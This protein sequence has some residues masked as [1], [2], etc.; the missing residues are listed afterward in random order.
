MSRKRNARWQDM[1]KGNIELAQLIKHFESFNRSERKS[2]RTVEWY[3]YVLEFFHKWLL[4]SGRATS[5]GGLDE[6]VARDFILYLQDRTVN[7]R[8]L[9]SHTV[10]NR[11]RGLRAFFSWLAREGYTE[12]NVL[13]DLRVPKTDNKLIEI[14]TEAEVD[15]LFRAINADSETGAR[16]TAL[17]ALFLDAGLRLTELATLKEQD[18]HLNERYIKVMGKGS[19]ERMLPLGAKCHR[20][21]LHYYYHLRPEP[22]HAG[23]DTF[24]LS[25]DGYPLTSDG[26]K[27]LIVRLAKSAQIPRL[28]PHLFRHTYATQFLLNGGDVF[29]LKQNLGHTTLAMV[30][31]YRHFASQLA[32][33]TSRSFS[34][35]DHM[36]APSLRRRSGNRP[37]LAYVYPNTGKARKEASNARA[38]G[39]IAGSKQSNSQMTTPTSPRRRRG[40]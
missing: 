2:P 22:A 20:T 16:N 18:V 7:G 8:R 1:D 36:D 9:S 15:R 38:I 6:N 14:L 11:V 24:F 37:E 30:E 26:V 31:H 27:S 19:K 28:H 12:T 25:M 35:L 13:A 29:L 23:A 40:A 4:D 32:A 21:M 17:I 5:L 3:G 39:R 10:A 33:V 34:P